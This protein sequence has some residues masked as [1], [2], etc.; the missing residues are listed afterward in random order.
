MT[1]PTKEQVEL[2]KDRIRSQIAEI[3]GRDEAVIKDDAHFFDVLHFDDLDDIQCI[4]AIEDEF[5]ISIRDDDDF[6]CVND[7]VKYLK[8]HHKHVFI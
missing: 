3:T 8:E 6:K 4:M 7:Y 5:E 1:E 2:V